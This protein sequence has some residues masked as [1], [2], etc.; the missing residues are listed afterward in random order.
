M[1]LKSNQ[2]YSLTTENG[3]N[4]LKNVRLFSEG[5]VTER[6]ANVEQPSCSSW[7]SDAEELVSDKDDS[8]TVNRINVEVFLDDLSSSHSLLGQLK[9]E[10]SRKVLDVLFI[11]YS[12]Q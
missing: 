12:W 11:P 8:G 2:I 4:M 5:N 1:E 3:A 9:Q 10:I 7:Q 6:A